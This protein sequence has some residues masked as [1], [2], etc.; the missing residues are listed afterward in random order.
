M[1]E[2]LAF[3]SLEQVAASLR[4]MP[5]TIGSLLALLDPALIE[6]QPTAADWSI[7]EVVAHLVTVDQVAFAGRI[8]LMLDQDIPALPGMDV[9]KVAREYAAGR[10]CADLLTELARQRIEHAELV[11]GLQPEQL[12][13]GGVH[14]R[15]GNVL[16]AD[17]VYEWPYHDSSH[18]QQIL[19]NV[20]K[21]TLPYMSR[22]MQEALTG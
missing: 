19:D 6:W 5:A 20:K 16:V 15:L 1:T 14:Q 13:R 21:A 12:Q 10:S 17:F 3:F 2:T 4:Q 7:K 11:A 9:D 8:H 18:V 22:R